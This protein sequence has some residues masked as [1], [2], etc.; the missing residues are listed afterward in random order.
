MM[1]EI[2]VSKKYHEKKLNKVILEELSNINYPMF[3]KLLRKKDIKVN[4]KRINKDILVYENDKIDIYLPKELEDVKIELDIV[5][6][7]ENILVI[8]KPANIEVTG[9]NSLTELINKQYTNCEFKP[10]PCHRIDRNTTGLVMFAKNDEALEILL[11]KFKEHEIEKH[12][13][14]ETKNTKKKWLF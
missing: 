12:Y 2:I 5:Y 14:D 8:N 7:D 10:Q 6:E 13:L 9:T 3:C 1:K 4:G 11:E